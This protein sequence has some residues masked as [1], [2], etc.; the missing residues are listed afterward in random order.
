[1]EALANIHWAIVLIMLPLV[2]A[3]VCVLWSRW[4][5]LTGLLTA[6]GV[7]LAV[8][9]LGWQLWQGGVYHHAIGGWGAPLGIELMADGL[10]LLMLSITA[11][12]GLGVSV[13]SAAYFGRDTAR[14]FWPLWLF[15]LAAL[16]ALFLSADIFNLYV[17]LELMG[18]AAVALAALAGGRDRA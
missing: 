4:A 6:A 15:L 16:N 14:H 5:M 12:V 17:T 2:A 13:Y 8:L 18:L 9:G 7:V 11:L 3:L 10:S 1:M